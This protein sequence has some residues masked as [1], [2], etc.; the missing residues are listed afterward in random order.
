M[1]CDECVELLTSMVF[2]ELSEEQSL[3]VFEHMSDCE[4]CRVALEELVNLKAELGEALT[5]KSAIEGLSDQ[6]KQNITSAVNK[7]VPVKPSKTFPSW[8][9]A[10]A[11]CLVIGLI[12]GVKL[13][14]D[15][16]YSLAKSEEA[17]E[18][19]AVGLEESV[20]E[21]EGGASAPAE[22]ISALKANEAK[23]ESFADADLSLQKDAKLEKAVAQDRKEAKKKMVSRSRKVQQATEIQ[24]L[25]ADTAGLADTENPVSTSLL[26]TMLTTFEKQTD[27]ADDQKSVLAKLKELK[28]DEIQLVVIALDKEAE[29]GTEKILLRILNKA[30]KAIDYAHIFVH[31]R[32]IIQVERVR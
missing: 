9:F 23:A 19:S 16:P 24:A 22:K 21:S 30:E 17:V 8:I 28:D 15:Q 27:L 1:K 20:K 6:Q 7:K 5:D 31:N 12:V 25:K 4:S 2:E 11:A 10:L 32:N 29:K 14:S 3:E 18:D 26:R 13:K